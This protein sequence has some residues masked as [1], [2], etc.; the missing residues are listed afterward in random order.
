MFK[1]V[2]DLTDVSK[3]KITDKDLNVEITAADM[4]KEFAKSVATNV[5]GEAVPFDGGMAFGAL[6]AA[7]GIISIKQ[8][9]NTPGRG[10]FRGQGILADTLKKGGHAKNSAEA[11]RMA[12]DMEK[13]IVAKHGKAD[14]FRKELKLKILI[15]LDIGKEIAKLEAQQ[16]AAK[17]GRR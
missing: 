8:Q 4:A 10:L 6:E 13:F 11:K 3:R 2:R 7:Y 16:K 15:C 1:A 5:A 17:K 12:A 9:T 14:F